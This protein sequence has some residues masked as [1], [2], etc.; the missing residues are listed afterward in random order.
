MMVMLGF[1]PARKVVEM[2]RSAFFGGLE[3]D[4]PLGRSALIRKHDSTPQFGFVG[5]RYLQKRVLL[6]GINP[7]NGPKYDLPTKGDARMMPAL[8]QFAEC[9]SL[10]H[11]ELASLAYQKECH[12]WPLWKRHCN[13]VLGPGRLLF[14]EIAYANCLPWRTESD[15]AFGDDVADKAARLYVMPLLLELAPQVVIALGKRAA[16]ILAMT[17]GPIKNLIVWNRAQ[18]ATARVKSDRAE[19]ASRIFAALS[20]YTA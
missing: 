17:G 9:P 4:L 7:G 13:E 6:I 3:T 20:A 11:F 16:S 10:E 19:A 8:M 1:R 2:G 18:A 5:A 15:S 14:D 12:A